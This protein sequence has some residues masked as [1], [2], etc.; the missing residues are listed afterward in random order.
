MPLAVRVVTEEQFTKWA[1]AAKDD[2]DKANEMLT[3]MIEAGK[4]TNQR[5]GPLK[6]CNNRIRPAAR[7]NR[8]AA[9]AFRGVFHGGF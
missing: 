5:C 2:L 8:D 9:K 3:A 6:R 1:E 4:K 7:S